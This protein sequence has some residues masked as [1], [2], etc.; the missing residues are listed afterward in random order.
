MRY[1]RMQDIAHACLATSF[2]IGDI[3]LIGVELDS[4]FFRKKYWGHFIRG[5]FWRN[6]CGAGKYTKYD[7]VNLK[8]DTG[9]VLRY[10]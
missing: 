9:P 7:I 6:L 3:L 1:V 2:T 5:R 8:A 10:L 4:T